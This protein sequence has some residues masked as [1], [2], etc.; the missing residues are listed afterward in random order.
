VRANQSSV[1]LSESFE[2]SK[3]FIQSTESLR[4]QYEV[5]PIIYYFD[6]LDLAIYLT[7]IMI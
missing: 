2:S 7:F 6:E 1:G 5:F 3:K 4:A